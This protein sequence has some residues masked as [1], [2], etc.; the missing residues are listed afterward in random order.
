MDIASYPTQ[1]SL[2]PV[3]SSLA[4]S[5]YF[6]IEDA[7]LLMRELP[8]QHV[9]VLAHLF[10]LLATIASFSAENKM[11]APNLG[12]M[13]GITSIRSPDGSVQI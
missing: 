4:E 6:D 1:Y 7:Q 3:G 11:S 13:F 2:K 8:E 12:M 9:R 5:R 10:E